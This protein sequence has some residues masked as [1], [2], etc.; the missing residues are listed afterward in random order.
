MVGVRCTW[1]AVERD[2]QMVTFMHI[3]YS[4]SPVEDE[5]FELYFIVTNYVPLIYQR[6]KAW[7][8]LN[9]NIVVSRLPISYLIAGG[10]TRT[11]AI[12][13]KNK[14]FVLRHIEIILT[15]RLLGI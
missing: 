3:F 2:G 15:L 8:Q 13:Q 14:D 6:N 9:V 7:F 1:R 12:K 11:T 5:F 10:S 4:F